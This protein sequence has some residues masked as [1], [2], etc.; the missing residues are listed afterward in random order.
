MLALVRGHTVR[1]LLCP[2]K[3]ISSTELLDYRRV[4]TRSARC[5][6]SYKKAAKNQILGSLSFLRFKSIGYAGFSTSQI[7]SPV[8][9]ESKRFKPYPSASECSKLLVQEAF[10]LES[11]RLLLGKAFFN[12][13]FIVSPPYIVFPPGN[14]LEGREV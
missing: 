9:M 14:S 8:P 3:T 4:F 7:V 5:A 6:G 11:T 10:F 2:G 12:N 13:S 1:S